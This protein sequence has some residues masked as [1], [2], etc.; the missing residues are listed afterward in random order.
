MVTTTVL[1]IEGCW[2]EM[3]HYFAFEYQPC[4]WLSENVEHWNLIWGI[5]ERVCEARKF[6][7]CIDILTY[8]T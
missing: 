1:G 3:G 2:S 6:I 7:L 5:E 4:D 8:Q